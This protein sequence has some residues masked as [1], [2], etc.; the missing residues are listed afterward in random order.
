[1]AKKKYCLEVNFGPMERKLIQEKKLDPRKKLGIIIEGT[2]GAM[3]LDVRSVGLQ[4]D[5]GVGYEPYDLLVSARGYD[6]MKEI[7]S[8]INGLSGYVAKFGEN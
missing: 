5:Y 2:I 4:I 1:M 8:N 3:G 6:L 7:K